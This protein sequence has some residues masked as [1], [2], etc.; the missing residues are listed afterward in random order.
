MKKLLIISLS[1]ITIITCTACK[2]K[3]GASIEKSEM[4]NIV[5]LATLECFYHNVAKSSQ[6]INNAWYKFW[7]KDKKRFW[8]EYSGVVTMGIDATLLNID[9]KNNNTIIITIPEAKVLG[10]KIDRKSLNEKSFYIDKDSAPITAEDEKK[11]LEVAQKSMEQEASKDKN[12]LIVAQQRAKNLLTNYINNIGNLTG[13]KYT[14]EWKEVK[15]VM[16]VNNFYN[17]YSL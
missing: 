14:I 4:K 16:K 10:T 12:Q 11:A 6:E 2:S 3:P 9:F 17:K 5:E 1:F 8:I 15:T 13:I 7:K